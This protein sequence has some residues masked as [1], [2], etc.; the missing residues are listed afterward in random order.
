MDWAIQRSTFNT[1]HSQFIT[2]TRSGRR[3]WR[4]P[5]TELFDGNLRSRLFEHLLDLLGL[6][7]RHAFLDRLRRAFD[8]ILRFLQAERSHFAD[9]LDHVDLLVA[10]TIEN[11]GEFR[12]LLDRGGSG[13]SRAAGR[14]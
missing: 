2:K 1:Q 3:L 9:G 14:G 6:V 13:G 4:R 7:L 11:N 5:E 8:E 12:L 10:G